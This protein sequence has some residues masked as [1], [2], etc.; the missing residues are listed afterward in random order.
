[1][2]TGERI[3]VQ[4]RRDGLTQEMLAIAA[5]LNKNTLA[6]I[7][8]A[9][10]AEPSGATIARLAK[11]LHVSTDY[12]L[13]LTDEPMRAQEQ[14]APQTDATDISGMARRACEAYMAEFMPNSSRTWN[15]LD[16][17]FHE[18]W[19]TIARAMLEVPHAEAL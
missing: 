2:K 17:I 12:L 11:A 3:H 16:A 18:K 1:M 10:I 8:R 9:N 19:Q 14:S 4:R 7:E 13:G 15:D 6:R 5:Q